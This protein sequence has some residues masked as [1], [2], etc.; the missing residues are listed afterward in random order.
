MLRNVSYKEDLTLKKSC[1][2]Y[3]ITFI[4]DSIQFSFP[5]ID[6]Y[7]HIL[8]FYAFRPSLDGCIL[9]S[10]MLNVFSD[11]THCW[12]IPV[13]TV[14]TSGTWRNDKAQNHYRDV[15]SIL[16]G[17]I[18][19]FQHRPGLE[20]CQ[21]SS[22]RRKAVGSCQECVAVKCTTTAHCTSTMHLHR[23][24]PVSQ[25]LSISIRPRR[26]TFGGWGGHHRNVHKHRVLFPVYV[27]CRKS[28]SGDVSRPTDK[29]C[30][31]ITKDDGHASELMLRQPLVEI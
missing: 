14:H 23:N 31:I 3:L 2:S 15:W 25:E 1:Q 4:L 26:D 5:T 19:R 9:F 21:V 6:K 17:F 13:W 29:T 28:D 11:T 16:I 7:L 10:Y 27:H 20:S 22:V 12:V 30:W 8:W 18:C 24:D